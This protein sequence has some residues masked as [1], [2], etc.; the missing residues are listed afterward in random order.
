M[1]FEKRIWCVAIAATW[2]A[3]AVIAHAYTYNSGPNYINQSATRCRAA[4]SVLGDLLRYNEGSVSVQ[5]TT[6]E[7]RLFCPL[8]RRATTSYGK[9]TGTDI[10]KRVYA[11]AIFIRALDGSSTRSLSCQSFASGMGSG[12]TYFG[13]TTYLCSQQYGCSSGTASYTGSNLIMLPQAYSLSGVLT[14]NWGYICDVPNGS[15]IYFAE[16]SVPSN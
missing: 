11:D 8:Q 1:K 3:S 10:E 12:A 4:T 6:S 14:A 2:T 9:T 5:P 7:R 13:Q 16:A 15:S